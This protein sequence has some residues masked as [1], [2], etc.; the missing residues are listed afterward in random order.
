MIPFFPLS[1][2]IVKEAGFY[3]VCFSTMKL[4]AEYVLNSDGD[5]MDKFILP[6]LPIPQSGGTGPQMVNCSRAP[7]VTGGKDG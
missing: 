5:T 1:F 3:S 2:Y 7:E 6:M 4:A